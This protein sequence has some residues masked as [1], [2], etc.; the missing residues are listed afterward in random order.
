MLDSVIGNY[1]ID[2]CCRTTISK[3]LAQDK[4]CAIAKHLKEFAEWLAGINPDPVKIKDELDKRYA[5][6]VSTTIVPIDTTRLKFVGDPK[7][8]VEIMVY[9]S[10]TCNLCKYV[11]GSIYDSI[12][13]GNLKGKARLMAKPFG[14]GIGD[15]A[16][17]AANALGK[18]WDLFMAMRKIKT[19]L[20]QESILS[21]ADGLGMPR[22]RFLPLLGDT[23]IKEMLSESRK[24]GGRNGV[25]VTPTF[26]I[27]GKRYGSYKDARWVI[28]ACLF[29]YQKK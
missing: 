8:P 4:G 19:R 3:C 14:A 29:E 23:T 7:A 10:S 13:A 28:D 2:Y 27:D 21:M 16:L 20:D 26:F 6:F 18:F 5:G 1:R 11:V 12:I 22:K 15:R 25:E 9:V 17:L 24:E